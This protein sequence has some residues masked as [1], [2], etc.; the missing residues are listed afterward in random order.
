MFGRVGSAGEEE[1]GVS[2]LVGQLTTR[3]EQGCE[4]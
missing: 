2:G 4:K 3:K 1:T